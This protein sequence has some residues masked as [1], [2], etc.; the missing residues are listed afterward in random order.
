MIEDTR[1]TF[2]VVIPLADAASA[3]QLRTCLE[4][5]EAQTVSPKEVIVVLG[6]HACPSL[7]AVLMEFGEIRVF[8]RQLHK[9]A[10]RNLGARYAKGDYLVHIDVDTFL[11]SDALKAA[12]GVIAETGAKAVLLGESVSPKNLLLRV[13]SLERRLYLCDA[14]LS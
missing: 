6:N 12:S 11:D 5:L 9:C 10:A 13:K 14:S 2:S 4:H 7:F 8:E 1:V 3:S